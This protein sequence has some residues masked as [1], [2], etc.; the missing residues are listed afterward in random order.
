MN[1]TSFGEYVNAGGSIQ[2]TAPRTTVILSKQSNR[3][4]QVNWLTKPA[5][6]N[7]RRSP[8]AST[9]GWGPPITGTGRPA[10]PVGRPAYGSHRSASPFYVGFPPP[11]RVHLHR[12]SR[13][14]HPTVIEGV[15]TD[16]WRDDSLPP[17]PP[18]FLA[19]YFTSAYMRTPRPPLWS[20]LGNPNS[21]PPHQNQ[22]QLSR[23]RSRIALVES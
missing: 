2:K 12:W 3:H 13:S 17:T 5:K 4:Q 6:N 11:L 16:R 15:D 23:C 10:P 22:S 18:R 8:K 19:P 9:R 21:Y 20:H 14:V 1:S 7:S